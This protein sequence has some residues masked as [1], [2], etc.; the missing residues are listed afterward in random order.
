M[1]ALLFDL[2]LIMGGSL[3]NIMGALNRGRVGGNHHKN[4]K[5]MCSVN[6]TVLRKK[7]QEFIGIFSLKFGRYIT[8]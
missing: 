8:L 5:E 6:I 7:R 1:A 2:L 3:L 4:Y